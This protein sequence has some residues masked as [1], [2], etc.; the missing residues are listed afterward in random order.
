MFLEVFWS[1]GLV[2]AFGDFDIDF[3]SSPES[4]HG[5]KPCAPN[6]LEQL[7]FRTFEC[8]SCFW[9]FVSGHSQ[10]PKERSFENPWA[11]GVGPS[12]LKP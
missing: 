4:A 6:Y 10:E 9:A 7:S 11:H 12:R 2:K 3:C 1:P 5:S 8:T